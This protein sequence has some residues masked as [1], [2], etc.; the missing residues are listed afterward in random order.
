MDMRMEQEMQSIIERH[1][2]VGLAAAVVKREGTVWSDSWGY[3]NLA[4]RLPMEPDTV[5]RIASVSKLAVAAAYLQLVEEGVCR[6]DQDIGELL[7]YPVRNPRY[8]DKPVTVVHLMTHTSGLRDVYAEFAAASRAQTV[9]RLPLTELILPGGRFHPDALWGGLEPGDPNGFDYSNLGAILLATAIEKVTSQRFDRY[10]RRRLFEPLGMNDTSFSLDAYDDL[11]KLAVLYEAAE[12]GGF[13][14]VMDDPAAG[15]PVQPNLAAYEPGTNAALFSPQGGLRT[16]IADLARFLGAHL[17]GGEWA[18]RRIL[19]P[20]S[21]ERMRRPEWTGRR[22]SGFFR[23]SGLQLQIT[24][25]LLPGIRLFGHAGDAYGLL[26]DFYYE[27]EAGWGFCFAMNGL[28]QRKESG[29][30]FAAEEEIA[31]LLYEKMFSPR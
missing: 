16:S 11:K 4:L 27:P 14:P 23:G 9:P 20:E 26:S 25:D 5:F 22:G 15:R 21:V 1:R 10:C 12:D 13:R 18:G 7:G 3:R 2:I 6:L 31:R 24:G 29:V 19:K 30:F 17:N 28:V 8:P